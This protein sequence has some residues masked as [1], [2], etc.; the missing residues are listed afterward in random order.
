MNALPAWLGSPLPA[1]EFLTTLRFHRVPVRSPGALA[2]ALWAFPLVGALIGIALF[3]IERGARE[4]APD[5]AVAAIVLI[6][7]V[8]LT[9]GLHLDGLADSCDG[10]FGGRDSEHRL[11]IMRDSRVGS[12]A[13]IG[14]GVVLIAKFSFLL[15]LPMEGRFAALLLAPIVARGLIVPLMAVTPY[16]RPEG[17]GAALHGTAARVGGLFTIAVALSAAGVVFHA[18]GLLLV[19]W[20]AA[21]VGTLALYARA[22][23]GGLTGDV[24]GALIELMEIATLLAIAVALQQGWLSPNL[25]DGG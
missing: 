24:D 3:G 11:E 22:K 14:I 21:I 23:L 5:V 20:A 9:G 12:W 10:L 19:V 6:A 16:A 4:L 25:W 15:A 1:L 17:L 7:W 18:E 2:G 8:V 13:I